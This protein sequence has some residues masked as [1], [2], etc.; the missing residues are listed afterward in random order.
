MQ[1]S[2]FFVVLALASAG[3][4]C[5]RAQ[6]GQTPAKP[7]PSRVP[8]RPLPPRV[9][10]VKASQTAPLK[11]ATPSG[12]SLGL[13]LLNA[14]G[15]ISTICPLERTDVS[16]QISGVV[17]RVTVRQRFSNPSKTPVE[18]LYTFPLPNEAAVD[19]M[20][21]RSGDR[22]IRGQIKK[23]EEARQIYEAAKAAGQSAAL[24][25]Q[26]RPNIFS[27]RVANLMPGQNVTVE[28]AMVQTVPYRA[29]RYEW[30]FPT[31]VGPRYT[32][33]GG[34]KVPGQRGEK[35]ALEMPGT[36]AIVTDAE[37]I[38]PPI[39]PQGVRAGHDLTMTVH[40]QSPV[41]LGEVS[42]ALHDVLVTR[43]GER[44]ASIALREGADVPNRDFVLRWKARDNKVTPG[45]LTHATN[46][47]G[48]FTLVVQPPV[49]APVAQIA[50]KQMIF[51]ID[52]TGSQSGAPIQKAKETMRYCI[53]HLNPND[54]FQLLGFNTEVF[55]CF[56]APV[57]A[58]PS[59]ISKAEAFLKPLEGSGGTDILK[60][61]QFVLKL[62]ADQE[63][64]RIVCYMTDGYVG[65]D[66]QIIDVLRKNRGD[67]R[68]FPFGVGNSV[69]R[70]LIDGMAREGRGV[71]EYVLL[72]EDGEAIAKRFY[73]RIAK[74]LLLNPDVNWH[75][76]PVADVYPKVL[77]DLFESGPI[78]LTG[79]FTKPADG[80][81]TVSGLLAGKPWSQDVR[82]SLP[83]NNSGGEGLPSLWARQKIEDLQAQDGMGAQSGQPNAN[84]KAQIVQTALRY[85]LM[86]QYTSFVAVEQRIVNVGGQQRTIDVP[87]EMP[88]GVSYNGIFGE[89]RRENLA[90]GGLAG[91]RS[92]NAL[93]RRG[94]ASA[95]S[96]T[97]TPMLAPP[98]VSQLQNRVPAPRTRIAQGLAYDADESAAP[99]QPNADIAS[100]SDAGQK[101]LDAMTPDARQKLL[102]ETKL[103]PALRAVKLPNVSNG[104]VTIQIWLNLPL[105][106]NAKLQ[107]Q[108]KTLGFDVAASLRPNLL[109]GT[110]PVAKLDALL[111]LRGVRFVET[112]QFKQN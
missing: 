12:S 110:L 27:Q 107:A 50:P 100:G 16:A 57:A 20:S 106:S 60:A 13:R 80:V 91:G 78:V 46:G 33:S 2:R 53:R 82:V 45:M 51:V 40:L 103:S 14:K 59:N 96:S 1:R 42:S 71:P 24:L 99:P 58:T 56:P 32:P 97:A 48:Y 6:F 25:D 95:G 39:T 9:Q 66:F 10:L 61:M 35:S 22:I 74:P 7:L 73:N 108:L 55:P 63:R 94:Y 87:V 112:P 36:D 49:A 88:D 84:I 18:A 72:N 30:T 102:R 37:K 90:F 28:I 92:L 47:D 62:P 93:A 76:L 54:T 79:R 104:R 26:E 29:G 75:D 70:F 98:P 44:D 41:A 111:A 38:T 101:R 85:Q 81:V 8:T 17:A 52:Q 15:A 89:S 5:A 68:F 83:R 3:A 69:N 109:L 67:T 31:V 11:A 105:A 23:R 21:L 77:P 19:A 86:S 65:N 4:L 64:P 34:Y 43:E